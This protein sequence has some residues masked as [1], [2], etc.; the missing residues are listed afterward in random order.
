MKRVIIIFIFMGIATIVNSAGERF[1]TGGT[2]WN[3][4]SSTTKGLPLIE[5]KLYDL[6]QST[7]GTGGMLKSTYDTNNNN[8]VDNSEKLGSKSS[9]TYITTILVYSTGSTMTGNLTVPEIKV[10]TINVNDNVGAIRITSNTIVSGD[11]EITDNTKGIIMTD[12]NESGKRARLRLKR[13][14]SNNWSVEIN[15]LP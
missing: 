6:E 9:D 2:Y 5:Q 14:V 15:E 8:I 4:V 7:S 11:I 3:G 10:S 12:I 1:T 13:D